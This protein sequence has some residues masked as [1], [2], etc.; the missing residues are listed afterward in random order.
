M[1]EQVVRPEAVLDGVGQEV[2]G[3][4]EVVKIL[5]SLGGIGVR[6]IEDKNLV[7]HEGQGDLH[8]LGE[9][10]KSLL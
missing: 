4:C 8:L 10:G 9:V 5:P 3:A 1:N 7:F 2:V 6:R